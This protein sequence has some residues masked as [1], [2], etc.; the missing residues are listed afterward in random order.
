MGNSNYSHYLYVHVQQRC[1]SSAYNR[2]SVN[3][4]IY[5]DCTHTK[6]S[7]LQIDCYRQFAVTEYDGKKIRNVC[8]SKGL[9]N[10]QIDFT[11]KYNGVLQWNICNGTSI[12][13]VPDIVVSP[14]SVLSR[15]PV[16]QIHELYKDTIASRGDCLQ[17]YNSYNI[18][19]NLA[20]K[21]R[22]TTYMRFDNNTINMLGVNMCHKTI[23][24]IVQQSLEHRDQ[25]KVL[26]SRNRDILQFTTCLLKSIEIDLP[27]I[28]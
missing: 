21:H 24:H 19:N 6:R 12:V 5:P 9:V 2:V 23:Y 10:E 25:Y 18:L 20:A 16:P 8:G 3:A 14:F 28:C 4:T 13:N 7:Q 1:G 15:S 11:K 26:P 22:N 17:G 27:E